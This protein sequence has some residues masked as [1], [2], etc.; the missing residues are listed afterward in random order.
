MHKRN[1]HSPGFTIV[2][3]LIVIVVIGI[4]AAISIVAYTGIQNRTYD[5]AVSSDLTQLAKQ[6]EIARISSTTDSYPSVS[7]HIAA[8]FTLNAAKTAYVIS[9]S[10][11]WNLIFCTTTS[12][13][14][15]EF[16]VLAT[17]KSGNQF[18]IQNSGSV[19]RNTGTSW[20]MNNANT[21]CDNARTGWIATS[22]GYS[23]VDGWRA[24]A[25][26]N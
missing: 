2:E 3:L 21:A 24:W 23:S 25:G 6:F 11:S 1:S 5:S 19:L 20:N 16:I 18:S 4:L 10:Q 9:P 26:G 17:S 12:D 14:K 13:P 22:A 7:T 8:A 15:Q